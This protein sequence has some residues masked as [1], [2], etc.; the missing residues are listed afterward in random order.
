MT[1]AEAINA[2]A[3]VAEA[4]RDTLSGDVVVAETEILRRNDV[5]SDKQIIY[6]IQSL[7]NHELKKIGLRRLEHNQPLEVRCRLCRHHS[8]R[9]DP[10]P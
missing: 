6:L 10:K 3:T 4:V 9:H 2:G 1:V 7:S 5:E 8:H